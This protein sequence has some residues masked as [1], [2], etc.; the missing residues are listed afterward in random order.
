MQHWII[1]GPPGEEALQFIY[2]GIILIDFPA[3]CFGVGLVHPS[4]DF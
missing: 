4:A 2:P 1:K 3:V